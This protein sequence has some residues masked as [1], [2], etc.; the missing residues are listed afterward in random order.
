MLESVLDLE[1]KALVIMSL[2]VTI[3]VS[4]YHIFFT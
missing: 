3:V 4:L 2:F 1:L